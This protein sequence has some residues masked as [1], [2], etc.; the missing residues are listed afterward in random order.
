MTS[1][2]RPADQIAEWH[3]QALV[4]LQQQR[5]E[6]AVLCW[7]RIVALAPDDVRAHAGL[8]RWAHSRGDLDAAGHHLAHAAAGSRG[9]P[10]PWIDV[11]LVHEQRGDVAA[12]EEAL[13][14]ALK[15]DPQDLLALLLRGAL[16]ER[17]GRPEQATDAFIAATLVAPPLEKLTPELHGAVA[18]ARDVRQRHEQRLAA[19]VDQALAPAL[20]AM[21]GENL[22]RFQLSV[23]ILLGRKKRQ[24]SRP[25]R[26]FVPHLDPVEFFDR[27]R[28]PWLDAMEAGTDLI[29]QELLA[30][31]RSDHG[32]TPYLQY[33][34]DQPV[35]QWAE[36]NRNLR[37][38]AYHLWKDGQPVPEHVAR[39]P[40]TARLLENTPRPH[41]AGRTP[42]AM[43][44]LLKPHTTIPPHVGASNAR[45]ICHLPLI[46]PPG[47]QFR[48]GNTV[49][50]WEP[51]RAWV[52]DD[53]IEHEAQNHSDQLRAILI[54][55]T[56]HPDLQPHE[57][58]LIAA[59]NAA[60]NAFGG[61]DPSFVA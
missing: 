49:R 36:L 45:L 58:Q 13:Y 3:R 37:W 28:M 53:T 24:E 59:L 20:D 14:R 2:A 22:G 4:A 40:E 47:C 25:L 23:D 15:E 33:S 39:C 55:D 34:D 32:I 11:A 48:V 29:R 60:L 61:A 35:E 52:F 57:R 8:G 18:H 12:Q 17:T 41:Q 56:W 21:T 19:F 27:S 7:Q 50:E 51:G 10:R 54:W 6:Q 9:N 1:P 43:F 16:L 46:V 30:V 44:S 38:S 42:V 26:Y 31:L 5:G